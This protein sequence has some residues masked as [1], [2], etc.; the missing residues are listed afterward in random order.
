MYLFYRHTTNS[1]KTKFEV[2]RIYGSLSLSVYELLEK[3]QILVQSEHLSKLQ[4][5]MKID[6]VSFHSTRLPFGASGNVIQLKLNHC[7]EYQDYS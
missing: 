3:H 5:N 4:I 7:K 2:N 1:P 6:P